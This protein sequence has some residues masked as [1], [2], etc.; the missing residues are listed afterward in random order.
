MPV[1]VIAGSTL[2]FQRTE[3]MHVDMEVLAEGV[4][5]STQTRG[6]FDIQFWRLFVDS[7]LDKLASYMGLDTVRRACRIVRETWAR[8]DRI[9]LSSPLDGQSPIVHWI[10]V[11]ID[12]GLETFIG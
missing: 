6:Q 1:L 11:M 7:R 3:D 2:Q 12:N 8:A 4:P 5:V 9:L 10:D